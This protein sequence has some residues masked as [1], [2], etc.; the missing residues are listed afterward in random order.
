[1]CQWDRV[2]SP[3]VHLQSIF[4]KVHRQQRG[5]EGRSLDKMWKENLVYIFIIKSD[6]KFMPYKEINWR[7]L[8]T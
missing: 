1:M 8:R 7:W 4:S 2:V 3:E 6:Y 5:N